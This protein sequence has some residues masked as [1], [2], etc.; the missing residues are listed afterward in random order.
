MTTITYKTGD[1]MAADEPAIAHGCNTHGVMGAGV[2]ALVRRKY[3]EV[4][5]A[6]SNACDT[7]RFRIGTAQPVVADDGLT[8]R[9]VY[10]LG[11]QENP[12]PDATTWGVFL[13][14]ANMAED[15]RVRGIDAIAIPR[16]GCG[17]G[18]LKW[19]AVEANI[20]AAI[21]HSTHPNLSIVVYDLP[22]TEPS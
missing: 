21:H 2:A 13:S 10:N 11:T 5:L 12:G 6:Y 3:P 8:S 19:D 22:G 4:F 7:G 1:L 16:I 9:W 15:A 20:I 17:I 18:G 14:F